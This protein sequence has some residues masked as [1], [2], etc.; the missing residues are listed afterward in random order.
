RHSDNRFER[1]RCC[2]WLAALY[3]FRLQADEGL[4]Q[5][6]LI[7]PQAWQQRLDRRY[8]DALDGLLGEARSQG[9]GQALASEL[10]LAY[11]GLQYAELAE[12]VRMAVRRHTGNRWMFRCGSLWEYPLTLHPSLA[13]L[14]SLSGQYPLLQERTAVRLDFSHSGW[15][16][17]FFLAMQA[18]QAAAVVNWSVDIAAEAGQPPQPPIRCWLRLIDE[19]VL[20][21]SAVDLGESADL[22]R[23]NDVFDFASDHLGLLK[24]AV[25][26]SGLVPAALEGTDQE[27]S[28]LLRILCGP[29]RGLELASEVA[30]IP[31][32][33]RLA[34]STNL[35]GSLIALCMRA[36]S[37]TAQLSGPLQEIERQVVA[38]RAILGEWLGGSGG[39]WQDSGGLW[40]GLKVLRGKVDPAADALAPGSLLPDYELLQL[41][42]QAQTALE[43]GLV[44][45]H[46]GMS[47]NV[48]PVLELVTSRFLVHWQAAAAAREELLSAFPRILSAL[49]AG[50]LQALGALTHALFTG[51][52]RQIIPG[53]SNAYV[54]DLISTARA[55]YG[56]AFYGFVMLGGM[57]GG[58]M[59]ML[60]D[61]LKRAEVD[62]SWPHHLAATAARHQAGLPFVVPP[63]VL[64]VAGNGEGTSASLLQGE[65]AVLSPSYYRLHAPRMTALREQ[66]LAPRRRQDLMTFL[67]GSAASDDEYRRL[68]KGMV[69]NLL[70]EPGN[71]GS[72]A[73]ADEAALVAAGLDLE[74][75]STVLA[76]YRRGAMSLQRNRLS[77]RAQ[78]R[79]VGPEHVRQPRPGAG[80][81][82]DPRGYGVVTLAGGLGSRWSGGAGVVKAL[83]PVAEFDGRWRSFLDLHL[84]KYARA[85]QQGQMPL[86]H[87]ITTS[88]LTDDALRDALRRLG[89]SDP[90]LIEPVRISRGAMLGQR[91]IPSQEDLLVHFRERP[92]QRLDAQAQKAQED[93]ER[94]LMAWAQAAGAGS[95]YPGRGAGECCNPPGH[96][97]ELPSLLLNGTLARLLAEQP[98]LHTL[99]VHNI[100]TLGAGFDAD[101]AATVA[102]SGST[103]AVEVIPRLAGDSGGALAL[104]DGVPR[105]I[106]GLAI[107]N[108]SLELGLRWYNSNTWWVQ[109]DGLLAWFG[110]QRSDL[111]DGPRVRRR[112]L[113]QASRVPMYVT[114]KDVRRAWGDGHADILP[115]AQFEQLWGDMSAM[116]DLSVSYIPVSRQRGQQLKEV[117]QVP[118]WLLD[119][120][121]AKVAAAC[122]FSR[123]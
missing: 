95:P 31:K 115:V 65:A 86:P 28:H 111:A 21:L 119:G 110:L 53:V 103:L 29:G 121:A 113:R 63:R 46:G 30:R 117:G 97:W 80:A 59:A 92:R 58:G 72:Q 22:R 77:E 108:E 11:H 71:Q 12:L 74:Q 33:S 101:I 25:V 118:D 106:E 82:I 34:V 5:T 85:R 73:S 54:D 100:D 81:D 24:A 87:I 67:Q 75:R 52:L 38:S 66:D 1:V 8:R 23:L 45:F 96:W 61:P 13:Q 16:D 20:R 94:A 3:R 93:A 84:A 88:F 40:P 27:L 41:S 51:P 83:A 104:I 35:L 42:P 2:A 55:A 26:A 37:Q 69:R 89:E 36:T 56:S 114:I 120:S 43:Q 10:A 6:P 70:P 60:V 107:P 98:Q 57:A 102:A 7:P 4:P 116:E 79:D 49:Q 14:D 15:S 123:P 9:L 105:I 91:V 68:L 112:V 76:A 109:I 17:I 122:G 90:A 99:I 47:G 19:P 39:G 18:P 62:A 44:V 48:G 78:I 64:R 50:N 32:G